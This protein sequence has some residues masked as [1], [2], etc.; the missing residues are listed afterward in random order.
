MKGR[1]CG[2]SYQDLRLE[3]AIAPPRLAIKTMKEE[4]WITKN[5]Q[6]IAV[7]DMSLSHLQN[8]LRKLIREGRIAPP[9]QDLP[10]DCIEEI[11]SAFG[12]VEWWK[13]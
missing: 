9:N 6:K 8:L 10:T 7:G 5:R 11:N 13:D 2:N 1:G 4:Y 12:C 3:T